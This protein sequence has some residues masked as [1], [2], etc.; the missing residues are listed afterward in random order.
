MRALVHILVAALLLV[1]IGVVG[2]L[3]YVKSTG[4]SG[5][6]VPGSIETRVARTIRGLAIPG[7]ARG[8][9]NPLGASVE[10]VQSGLE[11]FAKYCA[12]CHGNDGSGKDTPIGRGLFPKPPEM[13]ADATQ[14]LTDG[15]LF[16]IIEN[17]VRF[18]GMPA[19]GTGKV[20]PGGEKLAWELVA[21][22]RHLPRITADEISAMEAVNPL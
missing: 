14:R 4:L 3:V 20:D 6:P 22:I 10:V 11:H 1:A 18:T 12:M 16:Y 9:S 19:F 17:G 2:G 7:D 21:F 5:Q 13:R 15:E 8:R